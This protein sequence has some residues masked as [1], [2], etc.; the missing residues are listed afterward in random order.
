MLKKK[1]DPYVF[2]ENCPGKKFSKTK[3]ALTFGFF[4]I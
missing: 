1:G 4:K 3:G 2:N